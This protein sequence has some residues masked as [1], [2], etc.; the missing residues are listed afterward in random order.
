MARGRPP[1]AKPPENGVVISPE[2]KAEKTAALAWKK[3][4]PKVSFEV[5][6]VERDGKRIIKVYKV[7]SRSG[8]TTRQ[9][10]FQSSGGK[11]VCKAMTREDLIKNGVDPERLR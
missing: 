1:A 8:I 5:Y 2:T 3:E 7:E 10:V 4:T 9:L 11:D 6:P